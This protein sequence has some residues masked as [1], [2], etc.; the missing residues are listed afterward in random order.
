M[1]FFIT[2]KNVLGVQLQ[3]H[4]HRNCCQMAIIKSSDPLQYLLLSI[5]NPI[6]W[7]ALLIDGFYLI[8]RQGQT[9]LLS[10]GVTPLSSHKGRRSLFH[11]LFPLTYSLFF[12]VHTFPCFFLRFRKFFVIF[13]IFPSS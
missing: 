1:C 6:L 10:T 9:Y 3:T 7:L 2:T 12:L 5:Q 13:F 4:K 8:Q 11:Y